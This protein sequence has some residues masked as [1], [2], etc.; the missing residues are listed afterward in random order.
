MKWAVPDKSLVAWVQIDFNPNSFWNNIL[1]QNKTV[2][3]SQLGKA[4]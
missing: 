2:K 4:H 1:V 3:R